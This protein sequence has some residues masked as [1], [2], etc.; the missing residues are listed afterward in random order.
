MD[1]ALLENDDNTP[2]PVDIYVGRRLRLRREILRLSQEQVANAIGVTFQ[3]IQKYEQGRNRVSASR[4][5]DICQ[6]LNIPVTYLFQG[7]S[8]ES[9]L[10][11][12]TQTQIPA[13]LQETAAVFEGTGYMERTET[14]ELVRAFWRIPNAKARL[15]LLGLIQLLGRES[16]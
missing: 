16:E 7:L 10:Q 3:Q 12:R 6:V 13:V 5:Y 9:V 8:T 11:Q 14:L 2:D 1:G 15:E 4:L